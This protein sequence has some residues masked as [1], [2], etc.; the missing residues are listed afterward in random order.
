M[1]ILHIL[2]LFLVLNLSVLLRYNAQVLPADEVQALEQ[3]ARRARLSQWNP[4]QNSCV[5]NNLVTTSGDSGRTNVTCDC[6]FNSS[7]I[8]H[9]TSIELRQ[10]NLTGELPE[11]FVNLTY[12]RRIDLTR[13]YFNGSIPRRWASL[14]LT[15]LG[16][17]GNRIGGTI[18]RELGSVTTLTELTLQDNLI[19]GPLPP[20]LGNLRG[21]N[22]LGLSGN[23]FTGILSDT[24][25]NWRNLTD[26]RI[27]GSTLSGRLPDF[28]GNWTKLK[29]LDIQGTS[30]QGPIPSSISLLTELEQLR[31]SDM[32]VQ[33]MPF[34][35]LR[36][37]TKLTDL[38][39]RNCSIIGPIPSYIGENI[40]N[41]KRLDLSFN[42]F[43][44]TI[45]ES[46][47]TATNLQFMYLTNNSLTGV[48]GSWLQDTTFNF[49]ISYNNYTGTS[50][51]SCQTNNLID[52]CLKKD[53]PCPRNPNN[54]DLFINCGG[55][56]VLVEG[57]EYE[58][59]EVTMGPSSFY[60]ATK[61]ASSSTG[62]FLGN[63][64]R[65][66]IANTNQGNQSMYASA[67]LAPLS[68]KY[69]GRCLRTG[70]YTLKLHF[71]E[72]MFTA[73]EENN[74]RGRRIFDVYI[75]GNRVLSD[76]NIAEEAG[77]I[78][79]GIVKEYNV[80]VTS[81][82]LEIHL[83]WSG[84]GTVSLPSIGIYGPLISAITLTPNFDVSTGKGLSAGAIAGIVVGSVVGVLLILAVLWK[85]GYLGGKNDDNEL[86]GLELQTGYFTLRQ[87]K[88]AT[89]NF[90]PANKIGEG[91][92]GPV[93]KGVLSDGS[94]IAVKQLS[95]KS[96]QGNKEFITEIGMLSAVQNEQ[97]V[98]LY[99]CCI[100]S[101]QLLLIYEYMENNSLANALFG[102]PEQRLNL[103]WPTRQNICLGI[104]KGLR[105]LHEESRIKI[106]HRDMKASNVLLDKDMNAKISDFGL[107]KLDDEENT[108]ISTRVAGT[109]GYMAPEYAMRGYLTEKADVYSFGIVALEIVSGKSNTN[110]RP[111]E[112]FVYLLDWAYVLQ[113]QGNLLDLVD[114]VLEANYSEEEALKM[115]NISLL[116]SNP[117]PT[118]RPAMSAVVN[119][120]K[121]EMPIPAPFFLRGSMTDHMRMK[122]FEKLSHDSET[123]SSLYSHDSETQSFLYARDSQTESFTMDD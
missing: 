21:L 3:L 45:P 20:E 94:V 109:V 11:E 115:L 35:N 71:A 23:N 95:S 10:L 13:N 106:V 77:G 37:L 46:L 22:R 41:I 103:D 64:K 32:D 4:N 33:D 86:R 114:P 108:H 50:R 49:D 75:Q 39:L 91:G 80:N 5:T 73:D 88:A 15:F 27:D 89:G 30:L 47:E 122:A 57:R 82:T 120:L 25:G 67:R 90:D 70:S 113:E 7:T 116:C 97:L 96:K 60:S 6:T 56:R 54:Y 72:I 92:F 68:L 12:L 53:L 104:A 101:N 55:P 117:S 31:I 99:G 111:K 66:Y 38:V 24:F 76:F 62:D 98:R 36:T 83:Y 34:P 63:D 79:I 87:I 121:D 40:R 107:A 100:E 52:W 16:L 44:G 48:V 14:P 65:S 18:P 43:T 51:S 74:I 1:G 85:L 123:H 8:C 110:Y 102:R 69:Y 29:R 81:G 58:Q 84:K 105:Y 19:G 28:I 17:L 112:E 42:K 78:G 119:M 26:F 118:L 59:D 2:S 93:F 9:V 61:W